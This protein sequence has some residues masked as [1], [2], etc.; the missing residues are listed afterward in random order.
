MSSILKFNAVIA[1]QSD[2][3]SVVSFPANA[4]DVFEIARIERA[5][6]DDHGDLFGF[7]RPQ[8]SR[9]ILEIRDYLKEPQAVLP[10]SVVLAFTNKMEIK[11]LGDG[12]C[13]V[14]IDVSE[15]APG[16]IV[17]GQQRLTALEPLKER[18]FQVFVSAIL[19]SDDAELRKQFI[20]INNTR[21]LPKELIYELLPTV[22]GL[23]HRLS[24][25]SLAAHLTTKLN[26]FKGNDPE[27]SAFFGNIRQH[28]NPTG[29]ISST[30]VQKVIMNS[31][32]NGAIRELIKL[33]DGEQQSV[34]LISN[35]Y[36]AML[37][38]FPGAWIG[39]SPRN[40]RLKHSC[41]IVALGFVMEV[42]Y[43]MHGARNRD[44]F[45]EILAC[46]RH[47]K[48]CA[49]TS[50][51]WYFSPTD[52][53]EWDKIQHT[54]PD[55]RILTDHLVRIVRDQSNHRVLSVLSILKHNSV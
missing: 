29:T 15:G 39:Q 54:T 50:G 51:T 28:T 3:H 7:Q 17:D 1:R 16:L 38:L 48:V 20:L 5:G 53:R 22:D 44:D 12:F 30:A 45:Q 36:G 47:D 6:R 27:Q 9:H 52:I 35:F 23:P 34:D 19:C 18:N 41:G 8:V 43:A 13:E 10:N 37:D 4:T 14:S 33:D 55:L 31:R 21:P 11:E 46:L 42:A 25:R 24:S 32:S 40:S 2:T 49:W 26:Y